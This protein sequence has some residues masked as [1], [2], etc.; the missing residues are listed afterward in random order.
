[1]GKGKSGQVL[2]DQSGIILTSMGLK[3][4]F[5]DFHL[6]QHLDRRSQ[7]RLNVRGYHSDRR[8]RNLAHFDQSDRG[9]LRFF[10]LRWRHIE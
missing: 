2:E 9:G 10:P 1:M 3:R 5:R 8:M 6:R 4:F 7:N